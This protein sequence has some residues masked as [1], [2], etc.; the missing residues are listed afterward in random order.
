MS[1]EEERE[2]ERGRESALKYKKRNQI[3]DIVSWLGCISCTN[4]QTVR[5]GGE[6]DRREVK[7]REVKS[8]S[9]G[10]RGSTVGGE[11]V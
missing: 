10:A 11:R 9:R 3:A 4:R 1:Q 8:M 7:G 6:R 5:W 2:R